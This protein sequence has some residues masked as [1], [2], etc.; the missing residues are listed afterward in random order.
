MD[1]APIMARGFGVVG[2]PSM[3]ERCASGYQGFRIF[4]HAARPIAILRAER[5]DGFAR[6]TKRTFENDRSGESTQDSLSASAWVELTDLVEQSRFWAYQHGGVF[7][8]DARTM[9]VEACLN[10]QFR[11]I[12]FYPDREDLM[13]DVIKFL[14]AQ[15]P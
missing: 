11:S 10:N 4:E 2:E 3:L 6:I 5:I 12:S 8:P 9:W 14:L 1:Y 13:D 15:V 7:S